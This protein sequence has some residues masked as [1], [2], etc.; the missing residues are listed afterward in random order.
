MRRSARDPAASRPS[1]VRRGSA[2]RGWAGRASITG[3][4]GIGKTRLGEAIVEQ[5]RARGGTVLEARAYVGE[6]GIAYG[7]IVELL[8]AAVGDQAAT[9]RLERSGVRPELTRLLPGIHPG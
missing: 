1:P 8:R 2:R 3:E 6:R 5:I 7:P 4:S 9:E